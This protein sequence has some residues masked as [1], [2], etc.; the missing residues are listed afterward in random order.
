[1]PFYGDEYTARSMYDKLETE[2]NS[3]NSRR[4]KNA[5]EEVDRKRYL[6]LAY[7]IGLKG[8]ARMMSPMTIWNDY[9]ALVYAGVKIDIDKLFLSLCRDEGNSF[10]SDNILD[11]IFRGVNLFILLDQGFPTQSRDELNRFIECKVGLNEIFMLFSKLFSSSAENPDELYEIFAILKQ[12]RGCSKKRINK[13]MKK[14][15]KERLNEPLIRDVFEINPQRWT[16][17][18]VDTMLF[19]NR[20]IEARGSVFITHP[21]DHPAESLPEGVTVEDLLAFFSDEEIEEMKGEGFVGS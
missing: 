2:F 4:M 8:I 16:E 7:G 13:W 5:Q 15:I 3:G 14:T 17:L 11:F 9:E 18:G 19:K 20:W 21:I 1:M 6:F 12:K 10:I